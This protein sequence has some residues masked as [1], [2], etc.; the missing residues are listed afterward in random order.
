M[1]A[2]GSVSG[3]QNIN[4]NQGTLALTCNTTV[5]NATAGSICVNSGAT[6]SVGNSAPVPGVNISKPLVMSGGTLQTDD[7]SSNGN[8]TIAANIS[9]NAM[10]TALNGSEQLSPF[11]R[12]PRPTFMPRPA[13]R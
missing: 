1:R 7:A 11:H 6:L 13:P 12:W 5:D 9:L 3:V 2:H 10:P 4:V 8:A